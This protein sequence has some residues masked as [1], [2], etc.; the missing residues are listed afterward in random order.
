MFNFFYEDKH[1]RLS[2][3]A[4]SEIFDI[5]Y[6][7]EDEYDDLF[8]RMIDEHD[9]NEM[10]KEVCFIHPLADSLEVL[11]AVDVTHDRLRW[12]WDRN[13]YIDC[14]VLDL[15][16]NVHK[17]HHGERLFHLAEYITD[18]LNEER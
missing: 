11:F 10:V 8:V 1:Y 2:D 9:K 6:G 14:F 18:S 16:G 3:S 17:V 4:V 15:C 5:A 7:E 12:P 13:Q